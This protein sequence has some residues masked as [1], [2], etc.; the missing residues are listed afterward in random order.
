MGTYGSR[1]DEMA[2]LLDDLDSQI[3]RA[4]A[5]LASAQRAVSLRRPV[6]YEKTITVYHD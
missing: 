1:F 4:E 5:S 6:Q 3:R 2:V